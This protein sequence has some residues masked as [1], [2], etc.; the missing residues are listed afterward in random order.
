MVEGVYNLMKITSVNNDLVKEAAK[1]QQRKYRDES[2][3][4]L[5]EG[6]KCVREAIQYGITVEQL[7]I[8]EG[9][10]NFGFKDAIETNEAVLSKIS[11]TTS[12][13][14]VVGVAKQLK[15]DWKK[16]FKK[17]VLL[18]NI[19][20]AGNLGTILRSCCA[21]NVDGV[22]LYGDTID[23]YNPKCVRASVGNLWKVPVFNIKTFEELNKLCE[24]FLPIA[25]L[26]KKGNTVWLKEFKPQNKMLIMFGAESSGLSTEL[27]NYAQQKGSAITIEMSESVESLNLSISAGIILYKLFN[28]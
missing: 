18:E 28:E 23:L 15:R 22:I 16:D 21:F 6:E 14:K 1:L 10:D 20:D 7:F 12:S 2:G 25:T 17:L 8:L 19:K 3:K 9:E 4:F 26:P 27:T 13:P 11:T 5:L 24:D